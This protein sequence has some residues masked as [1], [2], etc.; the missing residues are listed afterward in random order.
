MIG[1]ENIGVSLGGKSILRGVDFSADAGDL[2]A[3]VGP[4]GAG[5]TTLV[6]ALTGELPYSGSASINGLD[7]RSAKPWQLAGIRA[8]L[9]QATTLAFPFTVREI[10]ALG[11]TS[12]VAGD[13]VHADSELVDAAL[14]QVDLSGFA[15]R[16]YQQLSGGEKQRV[17]LARVLCQIWEPVLDGAPR[18]LFL[19]EPVASLDIRH[20]L[21]IMQIARDF[22]ERGGGVVAV[23]HDLNLSAMFAE[24]ICVVSDGE[25]AAFGAPDQVISNDLLSRVFGCDLRVNELPDNR[26]PFILPHRAMV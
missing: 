12:G 9:P 11:F 3:I 18:W 25:I 10:V 16:F 21:T 7:V 14:R 23:M 8:V 1:A 20:Q 17:Q 24:Q 26:I 6:K 5:K 13:N 15:G 22:A 19:D 2:V 4:N